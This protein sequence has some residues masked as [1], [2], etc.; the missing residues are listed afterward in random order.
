MAIYGPVFQFTTSR[1]GRHGGYGN[2]NLITILS[3][4]DLPRRSTWGQ[5]FAG[6][7]SRLSIH[8]LPKRSTELMW[9]GKV[10]MLFQFTTSRGGRHEPSGKNRTGHCLSIHDLPRRPTLK[11]MYLC[12]LPV[13]FNSRPPEEVD[14]FME[15]VRGADCLSIHD[16]P[17]RSTTAGRWAIS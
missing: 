12:G 11:N 17:R 7:Y 6:V 4:H 15:Q 10:F 2:R 5:R 14:I 3:I 1:G 13:T 8:D 16:L 9:F